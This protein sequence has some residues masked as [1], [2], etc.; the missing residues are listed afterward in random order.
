MEYKNFS[1]TWQHLYPSIKRIQELIKA[2]SNDEP[3]SEY[4][5]HKLEFGFGQSIIYSLASLVEGFLT[6][7]FFR[8]V[9]HLRESNNKK[10]REIR[11]ALCE[12][13]ILLEDLSKIS[14]SK[15]KGNNYTTWFKILFDESLYDIVPKKKGAPDYEF[16]PKL[17][18][19]RN[20]LIHG[21][22]I[23]F[24]IPA[25]YYDTGNEESDLAYENAFNDLIR[26][27]KKVM[28]KKFEDEVYF[29]GKLV[30][31]SVVNLYVENVMKIL[32]LIEVFIDG[33]YPPIKILG[34]ETTYK[35]ASF[36]IED[37][38]NS[39]RWYDD[40]IKIKAIN[41]DSSSNTEEE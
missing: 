17:F 33:C 13:R 38:L 15:G 19:L 18:S 4:N 32:R 14:W 31:S 6:Y 24:N 3:T 7:R 40:N 2:L 22:I 26:F 1:P 36:S 23:E 25:D 28:G 21:Q 12:K 5:F 41:Q 39:D 8:Y 16:L 35:D 27:H 11:F 20:F 30:K 10:Y 34:K 29:V 9:I 37:L